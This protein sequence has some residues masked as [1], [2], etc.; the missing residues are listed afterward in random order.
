LKLSGIY[1][2]ITRDN[3]ILLAFLL[4]IPGFFSGI[5]SQENFSIGSRPA[6][7]ANAVVM[8]SDIWAVNHNQAGL[9]DY[10]NFSIGFHHENKYVVDEFA[11]HALALTVPVKPG[12]IGFSYTY[13]GY[14]RYNESKIG[15]GFGKSFGE[16]FSA[17]IQLNY[18]YIYA[19]PLYGNG[20]YE[21]RHALTVEG[22]IQYKPV[23]ALRIGIH[24]FNP[25][26]SSLSP[27]KIDTLVTTLRAGISFSPIEKLWMSLET[28]KSLRYNLRIK[29]GIEYQL[30]KGLFLRTGILTHPF[31]NTFGLG[32]CI[33]RINAD[34]AFSHNETLGFMPHFS[35]QY[36]I[37]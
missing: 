18:H 25:S 32:F 29:S 24:V 3:F 34:V 2:R 15:I 8:E 4:F 13:F 35:M 11:L 17:G 31:Q 16:K 10:H 9:G 36:R 1:N 6:A 33:S 19:S 21:N 30:N 23:K 37:K 7:L 26:R 28:E 14:S 27:T 22:G 12:T 5:Y 20:E